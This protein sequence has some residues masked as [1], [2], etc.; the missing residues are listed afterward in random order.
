MT[1]NDNKPPVYYVKRTNIYFKN[2]F[3][4]PLYKHN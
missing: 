4:I 3:K 2:N 1:A